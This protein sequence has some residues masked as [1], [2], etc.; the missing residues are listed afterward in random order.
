MQVSKFI[1]NI[2]FRLP[3]G[4]LA[5]FIFSKIA[6]KQLLQ[7]FHLLQYLPVIYAFSL[8]PNSDENQE[9]GNK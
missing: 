2:L 6:A 5:S 1:L 8:S 4:K 9:P 3:T 7:S